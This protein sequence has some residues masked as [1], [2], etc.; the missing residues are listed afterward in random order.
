MLNLNIDTSN[1]NTDFP[2]LEQGDVLCR[3][4]D[5]EV[6][7]GKNDWKGLAV[8]M[9]TVNPHPDTK[10]STINPGFQLRYSISLVQ[11]KNENAPPIEIAMARFL[12]AVFGPG[13]KVKGFNDQSLAEAKGR[14]VLAV[15]KKAKDPQYGETEC[16]GLKAVGS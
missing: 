8:K 13:G 16:K 11:S 15:I 9:Q 10:G 3:I 5:Y 4:V 2:A 1:T 6:V 12:E 14:E 7:E